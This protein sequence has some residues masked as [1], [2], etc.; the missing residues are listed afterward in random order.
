MGQTVDEAQQQREL[1]KE[2]LAESVDRFE[3]RLRAE[4]DWKTRLRRDGA[5]YAIIA[6][7]AAVTLVGLLVLRARLRTPDEPATRIGVSGLDD[8]A[9]EL[10]ALRD[11]LELIR[12]GKDKESQPL[13]HK[14]AIRGATAAAAAA[15]TR[16]ASSIMARVGQDGDD[17]LDR[18]AAE[19]FEGAPR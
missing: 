6:G 5:R 1:T 4:L 10:N 13:W 8:I 7:V 15:G 9:T 14:I 17:E 12:K 2:R 19:H 16:V 11:E 3:T 18:D